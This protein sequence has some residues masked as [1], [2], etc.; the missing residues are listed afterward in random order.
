MRATVCALLFLGLVGVG[1]G[2][3]SSPTSPSNPGD[4]SLVTVFINNSVYSPNPVTVNV[5]QQVNWKNNDTIAHT[6]TLEGM[7]DNHIAPMSAQGAPVTMNT[8]GTFNYHCTIHQGM[9]G[10]IVVQ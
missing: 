2:K 3:S 6:A 5:G 8:K 4:G 7:F 10:T 1:C 9:T